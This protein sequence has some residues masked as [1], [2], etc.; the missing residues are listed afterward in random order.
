MAESK[1]KDQVVFSAQFSPS[2]RVDEGTLLCFVRLAS[3]AHAN[4]PKRSAHGV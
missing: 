2:G 3:E 1:L 4:K